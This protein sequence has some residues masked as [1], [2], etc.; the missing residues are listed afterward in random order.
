M[1]ALFR[2]LPLALLAFPFSLLFLTACAAP[3][4][5]V[6]PPDVSSRTEAIVNGEPTRADEPAVVLVYDR[7]GGM[8]TGTLI[9]PRV[10]LTAK[11]CVQREGASTTTS[12][13]NFIVGIGDSV[14]ALTQTFNVS[15]VRTTPGVY[16][17]GSG[18][19]G[20]ALVGIDVGLITLTTGS[21]TTPIPVHR[22]S[23]RDLLGQP[24]RAIGFGETPSG[25]AGQKFRTMTSAD[26]I[27]GGVIYTAPTICRGD[28]GGPLLWPGPDGD[29]VFGIASFG[30]GPCGG[31][32]NGYNRVDTFL[33][34]IDEVVGDSGACLAN[35]AE[36]CDGFDNDC[37]GMVDEDCK[38]VGEACTDDSE[39]VTLTCAET[40]AGQVCTQACDPLRPFVGCPPGDYCSRASGCDGFCVP[41]VAGASGVGVA[42]T[43]DTDCDSL[44][45]MNPGD[46]VQRCLDPCQGDAGRCLAGEVCAASVGACGGC[47]PAEIVAGARGLGEGCAAAEECGSGNCLEDGNASYCTRSCASDSDCGGGY[48]CRDTDAGGVCVVGERGGT[49]S[50]CNVNA[51]CTADL[52][53]ASRGAGSWC[54]SFCAADP[55]CPG[56]FA[57]MEVGP[58]TRVCAPAA[59]GV[60]GEDCTTATDCL[61]GFCQGVG[62]RGE[63]RC[64]RLCGVDSSCGPGFECVRA[65][66]GV[67]AVC[68]AVPPP[69]GGG[70]GCAI[71]AA[72]AR[73]RAAALPMVGLLGLFGLLWLRRR[74][75]R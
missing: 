48:H 50:P 46:G 73:G 63:L 60:L 12:P 74:G 27:S 52:F 34:M 13:R 8:C 33:D 43:A 10:V 22:E 9:S 20:G 40:S 70:G 51:D 11:H 56:G 53:C 5:G 55:D 14:R 58:D 39:C 21:T 38:S 26:S 65:T 36:V 45:C 23:P 57:C 32:I 17:A 42:C 71:D 16:S 6:S 1:R 72:S 19:L 3:P 7:A 62:P 41:G 35:G 54:T 47:V 4:P 69:S 28:S 29:E 44:N 68:V 15:A 2:H 30:S 18:G 61:S 25:G 59:A 49:G 66:G 37:D 64:S 67:D 24:A 31:G 75:V